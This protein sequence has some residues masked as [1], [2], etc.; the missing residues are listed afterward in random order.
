M[1]KVQDFEFLTKQSSNNLADIPDNED[2]I[3]KYLVLRYVQ[4]KVYTWVGP[5]LLALNPRQPN[6]DLYDRTRQD[7]FTKS[8]NNSQ[9]E[10]LE[11]HVFAVAAQAR[12]RLACGLGKVH[13][14]I[15][16]SGDS[17]SG[18][19]FSACKILNFL[20]A[21]DQSNRDQTE[22]TLSQIGKACSVV[23]SFSTA[24]TERN[25]HSSR[26][27]Q[28]VQLQYVN[29]TIQG[30][31]INSFLLEQSR[32][33]GVCNNFHIF[34]QMLAGL[35]DSHLGTLKLSRTTL[36]KIITNDSHTI[37]NEDYVKGF[38]ETVEA[39]DYLRIGESQRHDIFKVIALLLHLRNIQF[40]ERL[41]VGCDVDVQKKESSNALEG[42]CHL[43][44]LP[45]PDLI[46]LL[47]TS[48]IT[49]RSR[50][51]RRSTYYCTITS[52]EG[53]NTRLHSIIR[54][55]YYRLFYW[56]IDRLNEILTSLKQK[57]KLLGVLD[58][59][60]FEFFSVNSIEQLSIN[61]A[62]E[63]MQL[64][65]VEKYLEASRSE[66]A[67]E[68]LSLSP[69]LSTATNHRERLAAI[70]NCLF[71]VLDDA[72]LIARTQKHS[73][74]DQ[75]VLPTSNA[76]TNFIHEKGET[77]AIRHYSRIVEYSTVDVLRKNTDKVPAELVST[78]SLCQNKF[79]LILL[80]KE[81]TNRQSH[82]QQEPGFDKK[83]KNT[84]LGKF[85]HSMDALMKELDEYDLHY[86]RCI[87][88]SNHI[89]EGEMMKDFKQQLACSGILDALLLARCALPIRLEYKEFI[90]RYSKQVT[91]EVK[92]PIWICKMILKLVLNG[93]ELQS[94]VHF[95]NRL[96]FLTEAVLYKL[97]LVR[98]EFRSQCASKIQCLW[99]KY[100][101]WNL[102]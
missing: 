2:L 65:F 29:G 30:A 24:S 82:L 88:P 96:I 37:L 67:S 52:V 9:Q 56:L 8:L 12:Y 69:P 5:V 42:A 31:V 41:T 79:I 27:G 89:D 44:G 35:A 84:T 75:L 74:F 43:L 15:V 85:K 40:Q 54:Y 81:N 21:T 72:C 90:K 48:M 38:Q 53:C 83:K 47:T 73:S 50:L 45:I 49:P 60:G 102:I 93:D 59:F 77:F 66:L 63:R 94:L 62:N 97:E 80:N 25:K 100:S 76:S 23:S 51:Q 22:S 58:I 11:P 95:G 78:F 1:T 32:V 46:K 55:L 17:G 70:E 92:D 10:L 61:Y 99:F 68:G 57:P 36:Y 34:G 18:K 86:I 87:K 20:A 6:S 64:H 14:V 3:V 28:L 101:E 39:M 7:H 16:I 33:T 98:D 91:A 19:T 4:G 13:Q 71:P 26:H